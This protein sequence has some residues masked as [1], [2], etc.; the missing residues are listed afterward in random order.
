MNDYILVLIG[1]YLVMYALIMEVENLISF[2]IF[3]MF[4]ALAGIYL[5]VV[6]A[7]NVFGS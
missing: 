5:I 3:K 4:P 2:L 7:N 6:S 1:S